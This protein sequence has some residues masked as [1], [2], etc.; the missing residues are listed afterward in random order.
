METPALGRA[1]RTE[2]ARRQ[3]QTHTPLRRLAMAPVPPPAQGLAIVQLLQYLIVPFAGAPRVANVVAVNKMSVDTRK[4][5]S[6]SALR[7]PTSTVF[8]PAL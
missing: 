7:L 5:A 8:V 3:L 1:T 4:V 6:V 2:Q